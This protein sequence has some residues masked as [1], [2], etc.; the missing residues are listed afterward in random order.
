MSQ[1]RK[2]DNS[3]IST[4]NIMML[5]FPTHIFISIWVAHCQNVSTFLATSFENFFPIYCWFSSEKS[6]YTKTFSLFEFCEHIFKSFKKSFGILWKKKILSIFIFGFYWSPF[7]EV[8][9]QVAD[10]WRMRQ[11]F[12]V[13][14][15]FVSIL[16]V[17]QTYTRIDRNCWIVIFQGS[18]LAPCKAEFQLKTNIG[19]DKWTY[20]TSCHG[21]IA[22]SPRKPRIFLG[23][24]RKSYTLHIY[25]IGKHIYPLTV[26]TRCNSGVSGS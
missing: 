4:S 1:S 5:A 23:I 9:N 10:S 18:S 20:K 24:R 12:F 11:T 17:S 13:V 19:M 25:S 15:G 14:H 7:P 22:C 26:L 2:S 6:V 16:K 21:I 8:T 3:S